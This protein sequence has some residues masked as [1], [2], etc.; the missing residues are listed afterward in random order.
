MNDYCTVT[1]YA[2]LTGKDPGNIRRMLIAGRLDGK[3]I[4]NQWVIKNDTAYP[5]DK[6]IRTGRYCDWR[7]RIAFRGKHQKLRGLL[8]DLVS[9]LCDIFQ[10]NLKAV[11][12][13]GSY[14]RGTQTDDSDMDI[15]VV[16]QKD[17]EESDHER[18]IDA[19]VDLELEYNIVLSVVVVKA[20]EYSAWGQKLPFFNNIQ[21]EGIKLWS[22]Q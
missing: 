15:A 21:K 12:L 14:A 8:D 16:L 10:D 3:K 20:D 9:S 17:I 11:I 4:G 6:R 19:I 5:E 22:I 1:E 13:Y 7:K 2:E 18:M